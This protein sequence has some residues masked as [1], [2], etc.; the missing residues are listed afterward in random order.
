MWASKFFLSLPFL[1]LSLPPPLPPSVPLFFFP[2]FLF[3]FFYL[4]FLAKSTF[5]SPQ[6]WNW[7]T[8]VG[9]EEG[10]NTN[11]KYRD[12]IVAIRQFTNPVNSWAGEAAETRLKGSRRS[13]VYCGGGW[14][15]N[16]TWNQFAFPSH[17]LL[18][19]SSP[20]GGPLPVTALSQRPSRQESKQGSSSFPA[21]I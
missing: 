19:A 11:R 1:F 2:P 14:G 8:K 5:F 10:E 13:G 16:A 9:G 15:G 21:T 18:W 12:K 3:F 17:I 6:N 7:R 4:F 20:Q